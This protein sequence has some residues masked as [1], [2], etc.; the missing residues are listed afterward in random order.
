MTRMTRPDCAVMCN[1]INTHTHTHKHT[2]C[3]R[4]KNCVLLFY[5]HLNG[6][7]DSVADQD[8]VRGI[9]V[10][11]VQEDHRLEKE[12]HDHSANRYA[13]QGPAETPITDT[14]Y[15]LSGEVQSSQTGFLNVMEKIYQILLVI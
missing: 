1:L 9:V 2:Q 7:T 15:M 5:A 10:E 4:T 14:N 8:H 3:Y 6:E 13:F 11:E 12:V